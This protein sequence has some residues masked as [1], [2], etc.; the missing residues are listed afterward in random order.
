[1]P[2]KA[3]PKPGAKAKPGAKGVPAANEPPPEA[4]SP[5]QRPAVS[6][7]QADAAIAELTEEDRDELADVDEP[8]ESVAR[9]MH[10]MLELLGDP[11]PGSWAAAKATLADFSALLRE[12]RALGP[13]GP[14]AAQVQTAC[15]H[16]QAANFGS[17][18]AETPCS[19]PASPTPKVKA[20]AG[21]RGKAAPSAKAA[22]KPPPPP[23]GAKAAFALAQLV[24]A[25]ITARSDKPP[26]FPMV[27]PTVPFSQLY[28]RLQQA[29]LGRQS[30]CIVCPHHSAAHAAMR[31]CERSGA[32][33]CN[34]AALQLRVSLSKT[35]QLEGA[36]GELGGHIKDAVLGGKRLVLM[37]GPAPPNLRFFCDSK[38]V[39][40][41]VFD[42]EKNQELAD[43]MDLKSVTEGFHTVVIVTMSQARAEK[44][45]KKMVP[46]FDEM[47][48]L[49]LDPAT[50]PA[51][52][53]LD[54]EAAP[55]L[56][57]GKLRSALA[58]LALPPEDAA[59]VTAVPAA[60][61]AAAPADSTKAVG[62]VVPAAAAK[63]SAS[64]AG[65]GGAAVKA[66]SAAAASS[67]QTAMS[68]VPAAAQLEDIDAPGVNK[69]EFEWFEKFD[70]SW[71]T[72]WSRG[73]ATSDEN[74]K[75]IRTSL[76][77][78]DLINWPSNPKDARPC[79]QLMS[80]APAAPCTGIWT[81][82]EPLCRPTEV[83][84]EFTMNGK[85]DLQN[86]CVLFT[87]NPYEGALPECKV[88][89]HFT[90]RGG[91]Q[92]VGGSQNIVRISNDGKVH[93]EKWNKVLLKIDWDERCL[94]GQ[95]DTRGKGYAPAVQT[96]PFRDATCQ[97]FGYLYIYN[98]D[99]QGTCWFSWLRVK[100][101]HGATLGECK[102]GLDDRAVI[103]ARLKQKEYDIAVAA[104]M[105]VGMKMG[106]IKST[107]T[108][109]MNL[110]EEQ[111]N[112]DASAAGAAMAR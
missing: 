43:A 21:A 34:V 100:Q 15:G 79:L 89:V 81:S 95:V 109:G 94:Y 82:F 53:A 44:Q 78:T 28:A 29:F 65:V 66:S 72:R 83:E 26:A 108:H 106:A 37:L 49:I 68:A 62:G 8:A 111:A 99:T 5:V 11:E 101:E 45:L 71:E 63:A 76:I 10:A 91:M 92:L 51:P 12:L 69:E 24:E 42:A 75:E 14:S 32:L 50:L 25:L 31:L 90:V 98:M 27:W 85:I 70:S 60:G 102:G 103:A 47:A 7:P 67:V 48:V 19:P 39:P 110:C 73:P 13:W 54:A 35:L 56:R 96:V 87:E 17:L 77:K 36:I 46:L 97:G 59:T 58:L 57:P 33:V 2:A 84:F 52:G 23:P 88:G 1:M 93:N 41:Q 74:G 38:R 18:R 80:G 22:A 20:K 107:A 55:R 30:A 16:L 3:K 104:D 105:E 64:A 86:A 4:P 61:A 112:N 6:I 40:I 9:I